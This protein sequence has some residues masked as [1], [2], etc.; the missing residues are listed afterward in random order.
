MHG[1]HA[2]LGEIW[3]RIGVPEVTMIRY[4]GSNQREELKRKHVKK[5]KIFLSTLNYNKE[6]EF[7]FKQIL[8]F[9]LKIFPNFWRRSLDGQEMIVE[10]R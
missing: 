2:C 9:C 3:S 8:Y 10:I 7:I 5:D 6:E 4:G 1:T